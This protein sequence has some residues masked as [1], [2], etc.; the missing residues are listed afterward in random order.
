VVTLRGSRSVPAVLLV[1]TGFGAVRA[2]AGPAFSAL[3]PELVPAAELPRAL[4]MVSSVFQF[5]AVGGPALGGFLFARHGAAVTYGIGVLLLLC[6]ALLV[7]SLPRRPAPQLAKQARAVWAG[8]HYVRYKPVLLGAMSL[9]RFAVLLGGA[10]ALLPAVAQDVLH[11]GPAAFGWL[12]SAPALG[13][14]LTGVLLSRFPIERRVGPLMLG[15]VSVFGLATLGFGLSREFW[16]SLILLFVSGASDMVSVVLRHS[17]IQLETPDDMRGRVSAVS[18]LFI[19]ASNEL[20]ELES[21][22]TAAW[23]GVTGAILLGGAGT[24]LVVGLWALWFPTLRR[25]DRLQ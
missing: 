5:A 2:F 14:V 13:A 20:G 23:L 12:R 16:L 1:A 17:L 3:V 24:L 9:D 19:G 18:Q 22:V 8:L 21:G 10:V 25:A 11:V 4:A 15:A 7:A 6:A